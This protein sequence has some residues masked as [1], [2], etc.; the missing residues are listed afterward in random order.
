M[1]PAWP[2]R[3]KA[4]LLRRARIL[5]GVGG[6]LGLPIDLCLQAGPVRLLERRV[7]ADLGSDHLPVL[8]RFSF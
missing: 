1:A 5:P 6:L 4:A 7:E 3:L 2:E 8:T